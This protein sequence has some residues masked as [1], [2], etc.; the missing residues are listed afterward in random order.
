MLEQIVSGLTQEFGTDAGGQS[1]LMR[2]V[3][4]WLARRGTG[5][6]ELVKQFEQRGLGPEASSWVGTGDNLPITP[7][8]LTHG[9]GQENLNEIAAQA[10]VAPETASQQLTQLLPSLIDKLTPQG[11]VP[12]Q[13]LVSQ[14]LQMLMSQL[15]GGT[16]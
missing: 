3:L 10:G 14:G 9:L 4:S 15:R 11:H 2:A 13:S 8:N 1:V 7:T 5:L 12:E 16:R 6:A